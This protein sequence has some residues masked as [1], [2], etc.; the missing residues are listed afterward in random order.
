VDPHRIIRCRIAM[1]RLTEA[2]H[3]LDV[4]WAFD[5]AGLL[6]VLV[7]GIGETVEPA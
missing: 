6:A 7:A 2:L 3:V 5:Y 1:S 4:A